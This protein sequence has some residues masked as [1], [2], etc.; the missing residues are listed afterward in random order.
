MAEGNGLLNRPVGISPQRG[1]ESRPLRCAAHFGVGG[2]R[3]PKG[4]GKRIF[5][6]CRGDTTLSEVEGEARGAE[7][8]W[9]SANGG[10][11]FQSRPLRFLMRKALT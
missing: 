10:F 6:R 3:A 8:L 11:G 5:P 9:K 1:F 2:I 7:P 4:C